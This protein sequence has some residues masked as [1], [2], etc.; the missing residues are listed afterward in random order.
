MSQ[1]D[2]PKLDGYGCSS[3]SRQQK[4]GLI[5]RDF[6]TGFSSDSADLHAKGKKREAQAGETK[7]RHGATG[8]PG[9]QSVRSSGM[10][11]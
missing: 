10:S 11:S 2:G 3:R 1:M 7:R 5:D 4:T 9:L 8:Q 6:P